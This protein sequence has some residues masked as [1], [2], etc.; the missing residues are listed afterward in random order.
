MHFQTVTS[1]CS[2]S[3]GHAVLQW[4]SYAEYQS[5]NVP[6]PPAE[7]RG[8]CTET[9]LILISLFFIL[10]TRIYCSSTTLI[11]TVTSI[12]QTAIGIRSVLSEIQTFHH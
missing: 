7:T 12:N 5:I 9:S 3:A 11:I 6:H 10:Y 1:Y 2:L 4:Q 8:D